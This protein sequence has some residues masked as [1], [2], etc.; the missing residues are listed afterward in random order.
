MRSI[1][2]AISQHMMDRGWDLSSGGAYGTDE[3]FMTPYRAHPQRCQYWSPGGRR[4]NYWQP[5]RPLY[6]ELDAFDMAE[7]LIGAAHWNNLEDF[8]QRAH[9]RNIHIVMGHDLDTP[10]DLVICWTPNGEAVG[11]TRT[12]IVLAEARGIPVFN[13]GDIHATT[14]RLENIIEQVESYNG[15]LDRDDHE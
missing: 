12:A 6:A 1:I 4:E 13:V 11:G 2:Q 9:A 14:A 10:V 15:K 8:G 7:D 5:M 3:C